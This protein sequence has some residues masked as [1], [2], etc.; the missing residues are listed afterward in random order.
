MTDPGVEAAHDLDLHSINEAS[1]IPEIGM[2]QG[3]RNPGRLGDLFKGDQQR[4]VFCQQRFC[5]VGDQA[6]PRV[7]IKA[8]SPGAQA[9]VPDKVTS[10]SD[11]PG[12]RGWWQATK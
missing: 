10:V 1:T 2:D 5:S 8:G 7:W 4:I 9:D 12:A 11:S 6:A 3:S